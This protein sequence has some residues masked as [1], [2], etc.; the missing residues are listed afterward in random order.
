[1]WCWKDADSLNPSPATCWQLIVV[2]VTTQLI[3]K[4]KAQ[5]LKST[6]LLS[7]LSEIMY[8]QYSTHS[9]AQIY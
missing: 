2:K 8:T 9:L 3:S 7:G 6:G 5:T 1:M 4:I